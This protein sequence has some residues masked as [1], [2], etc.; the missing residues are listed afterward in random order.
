[1]EDIRFSETVIGRSALLAVTAGVRATNS[2]LRLYVTIAE[3]YTLGL[4]PTI[5]VGTSAK[6]FFDGVADFAKELNKSIGRESFV[7]SQAFTKNVTRVLRVHEFC[8]A[9]GWDTLKFISCFSSSPQKAVE[10]LFGKPVADVAPV[11][12]TEAEAEAEAE[13]EGSVK[14]DIVEVAIGLFGQ[15]NAEQLAECAVALMSMTSLKAAA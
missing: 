14:K 3:Q 6:V 8:V 9:F 4:V 11:D 2:A 12:A 1:M 15:M 7:G 5:T 10:A 13:A